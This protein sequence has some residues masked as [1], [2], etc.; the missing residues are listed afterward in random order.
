[1]LRR[2]ISVLLNRQALGS[3]EI[4]K[5]FDYGAAVMESAPGEVKR[6]FESADVSIDE[7]VGKVRSVTFLK[8]T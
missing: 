3:V 4:L 1:M 2:I 6:L 8:P 7:L 5:D